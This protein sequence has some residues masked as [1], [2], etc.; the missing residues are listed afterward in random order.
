MLKTKA[1]D[2]NTLKDVIKYIFRHYPHKGELS[3]ARL[4][5]MI[6]LSDWKFCILYNK[7]I[8]SI[9]WI[10]NHYGPYVS[11]VIELIEHDDDFVVKHVVNMFGDSKALI[12]LKDE[13]KAPEVSRE[14]S[15]VLSFV[16]NKT[17]ML[18][19]ND[20]IN[21]IYST[22]PIVT[23]DRY[24]MLDLAELATEYKSKTITSCS[25]NQ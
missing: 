20:F 16:I 6:Y 18:N 11:D 24:S 19:W 4:V 13:A 21:L 5:K 17:F 9:K 22:Y 25:K 15:D 7:Q 8:T 3:K 14:V 12:Y 2:M 10:F 23:K 1:F